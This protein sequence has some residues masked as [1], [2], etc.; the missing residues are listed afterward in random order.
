MKFTTTTVDELSESKQ[1]TAVTN[2][3]FNRVM[4]LVPHHKPQL[5]IIIP[6][7]YLHTLNFLQIRCQLCVDYIGADGGIKLLSDVASDASKVGFSSG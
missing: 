3:L 6:F 1:T 5:I 2:K 4:I 7:A